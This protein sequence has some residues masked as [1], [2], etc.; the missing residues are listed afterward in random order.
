M[1]MI[2]FD[3]DVYQQHSRRL[4]NQPLIW[5]DICFCISGNNWEFIRR[6]WGDRIGSNCWKKCFVIISHFWCF[7]KL[8]PDS[9]CFCFFSV[10]DNELLY[11]NRDGDVVKY[12]VDTDEQTILVHN[13]KFVSPSCFLLFPIFWLH[14]YYF[15]V[16]GPIAS[17][18]FKQLFSNPWMKFPTALIAQPNQML[19]YFN[20]IWCLVTGTKSRYKCCMKTVVAPVTTHYICHQNV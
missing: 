16:T 5:V 12:N 10:A 7:Y 2:Y 13:K 20:H 1:V 18:A 19:H 3:F 6:S 11:R 17:H 4:W 15:I 8:C 14:L 9:S